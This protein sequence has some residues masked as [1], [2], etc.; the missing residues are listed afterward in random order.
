MRYWRSGA[1]KRE[2]GGWVIPTFPHIRGGG[3]LDRVLLYPGNFVPAA[4]LLPGGEGGG[5]QGEDVEEEIYFPALAL[6]SKAVGDHFPVILA[7]PFGELPPR[8]AGKKMILDG[9]TEEGWGAKNAEV[10][11]SC[12]KYRVECSTHMETRSEHGR[13]RQQ[14][15]GELLNATKKYRQV[16]CIIEKAFRDQIRPLRPVEHESPMRRFLLQNTSHPRMDSPLRALA[17]GNGRE[18]EKLVS[19]VSADG[20][21]TFLAATRRNNT[22]AM[23][24]Y[25]A[26]EEERNKWGDAPAHWAP[27][28][29]GRWADEM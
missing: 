15:S 24:R 18:A 23:F 5:E 13:K 12:E 14:N 17:T 6:L 28:V 3:A 27:L 19:I 8:A 11:E 22:R 9:L 1:A 4:L 20:L 16:E 10:V 25:L 7:L 29:C 26:R 21:R 2:C